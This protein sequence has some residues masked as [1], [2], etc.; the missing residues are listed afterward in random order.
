[1]TALPAPI[2]QQGPMAL[3]CMAS[4][5]THLNEGCLTIDRVLQ[6]CQSSAFRMA[7]RKRGLTGVLPYGL[8]RALLPRPQACSVQFWRSYG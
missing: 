4:D 7:V 6:Q 5:L 8:F 2:K 3:A 1:M